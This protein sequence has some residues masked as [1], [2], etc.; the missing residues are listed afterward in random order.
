MSVMKPVH[1]LA[2]ALALACLILP[3][4]ALARDRAP[5]KT[6]RVA[7]LPVVNVSPEPLAVQTVS[8]ALHEQLSKLDP[9]RATFL[10]PSDVERILSAHNAMQRATDIVDR[11]G[12]NDTL[13]STAV[14]GLDTLL[15]VDAILC[16]RVTEWEVRRI[17]VINAG[18]SYTTI[19]AQFALYD[20]PTKK[21]LWKKDAR[22]QRYAP[23]YDVSSG[24]V[25]YDAIGNIQSRST[26][27]APEPKGVAS[28]LIRTAFRKF[29]NS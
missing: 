8:Q 28:E 17:T 5:M 3:A 27:E 21:L 4:P 19:G 25:S 9:S 22:V 15:T 11:W 14:V 10:Y 1:P 12:K 6:L 18:Q 23:E 16:V 24:T 2:L 20:I 29:P 26:N 7:V 13:D